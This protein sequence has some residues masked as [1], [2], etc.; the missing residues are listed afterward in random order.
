MPTH[1]QKAVAKQR[2][3]P[4][5]PPEF[6]I[7]DYKDSPIPAY[8]GNPLI[9]ALTPIVENDRI[10]HDMR[11]LP[12]FKPLQRNDAKELR[13]HHILGLMEFFIPLGRHLELAETIDQMIR[14]GYR[15]RNPKTPDF[16]KQLQENYRRRQNGDYTV[17][18]P[19]T[20]PTCQ[21]AAIVGVSGG[22]KTGTVTRAL[23]RYH[24]VI[25]HPKL[26]DKIYQIP[27]LRLECPHNGKITQLCSEFFGRVDERL[28]T[29]YAQRFDRA[30]I[31]DNILVDQINAI[32]TKHAIGIIVID[33]LQHIKPR[34]D[35]Q[36]KEFMNFLVNLV[37]RSV[38]PIIFIGTMACADVLQNTFR[39]A[40]RSI[41][42][43]WLNYELGPDW[44][45]LMNEMWQY[46]WTK[47]QAPL[48][49]EILAVIYDETQGVLDLAVKL[50]M[51]SQ[52]RAIV[53]GN[54]ILSTG[55]IR[56]VAKERLKVVKPMI[57]ALR[58]GNAA[59]MAKYDD[60]SPLNFEAEWLQAVEGR[61]RAIPLSRI[62]LIEAAENGA[63]TARIAKEEAEAEN[64]AAGSNDS[65]AQSSAASD[66][67]AVR[68][69]VKRGRKS[70]KSTSSSSV[71]LAEKVSAGL[72]GT[73]TE[74]L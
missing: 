72:T 17:P 27:W 20:A 12:L 24:R 30:G 32:A 28:G 46:Q 6:V 22:G 64:S 43:E 45:Y 37:N 3:K 48:T 13:Y 19:R 36:I 8:Q 9:Q 49:D 26:K 7:A 34:T 5:E 55:L 74:H 47:Q 65:S 35:R 11:Q 21:S 68:A 38:V 66:A 61:P 69:T 58:S 73:V 67:P 59:M 56:Q 39:Q 33:E 63:K 23:N 50:F 18:I 57:D 2:P 54:E 10:Y 41:G 29:D 31:N 51:F 4:T 53:T 60:L 25:Y 16:K 71:E 70:S 14:T 1:A 52:Q 44:T 62:K 40:R 42:H 15:G